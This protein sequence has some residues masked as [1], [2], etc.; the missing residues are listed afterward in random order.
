M[1]QTT[2]KLVPAGA[3][4]HLQLMAAADR[5]LVIE[6]RSGLG[7][8]S[9]LV[10]KGK[11]E[12]LSARMRECFGAELPCGPHRMVAADVAVAGVAPGTWIVTR[13]QAGNGFAVSLRDLIGDIAAV[14]DQSDGYAVLRLSGAKVHEVLGKL[15]SFDVHPQVFRVGDCATSVIAHIGATLW[16]LDA[17][18][19]EILIYRSFAASFAHV[20]RES[21][22][23]IG[24]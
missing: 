20:L 21:T 23:G 4:A 9:M 12:A 8:C 6:E 5:G 13:E 11:G 3:F 10:R 2:F 24:G 14:V 16:R 19:F 17:A 7:I 22:A 18:V 15:V 1:Q